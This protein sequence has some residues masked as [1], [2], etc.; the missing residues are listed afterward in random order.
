[1]DFFI[2]CISMIF[3]FAV[4]SILQRNFRFGNPK[5]IHMA[6]LF[7]YVRFEN[8]RHFRYFY[9]V[10]AEAISW[11]TKKTTLLGCT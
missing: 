1:M 8:G 3:Y 5:K 9:T 11:P 7:K 6:A 2:Y 10:Y 4:Q